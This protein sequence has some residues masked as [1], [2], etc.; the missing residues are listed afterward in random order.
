MKLMSL[1]HEDD[2]CSILWFFLISI[3][4]II[5]AYP[6]Y[7][8]HITLRCTFEQ[9]SNE[10]LCLY[11]SIQNEWRLKRGQNG[12]TL[13]VFNSWTPRF[14]ISSH[15]TRL[16]LLFYFILLFKT[17]LQKHQVC[18]KCARNRTAGFHCASPLVSEPV[19]VKI[20]SAP[21]LEKS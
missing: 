10:H 16:L 17:V 3:L 11:F 15:K 12:D 2:L 19:G 20:L 5:Y 14:Q 9:C 18:S 13:L 21:L 7:N 6:G 8:N 1:E 4:F